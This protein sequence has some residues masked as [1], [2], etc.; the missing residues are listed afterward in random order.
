MG[1]VF[2]SVCVSAVR[3]CVSVSV[4]LVGGDDEDK[5]GAGDKGGRLYARSRSGNANQEATRRYRSGT[6]QF[7]GTESGP[8]HS[9]APSRVVS[10]NDHRPPLNRSATS[11]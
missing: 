11:Q 1:A 10:V 5:V 2:G 9:L 3:V 6:P 7:G 4:C 8:N